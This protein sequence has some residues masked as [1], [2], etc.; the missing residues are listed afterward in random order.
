MKGLIVRWLILTIAI[1]TAAYF[2]RGIS[3]SSFTA[4]F[5][6]AAVLGILNALFKPIL[7]LLTLPI[8]ILTLGLFTFI[9]NAV[10]LKMTAG[11]IP[12]FEL[13]GFWP[14]VLGALVISIVNWL[15]HLLIAD[16]GK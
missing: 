1:L 11:I 14:A 7:I 9:I 16:S 5:F 12:G 4:A 6:A 10:L 8:N 15:L 13:Q 3:V 2:I